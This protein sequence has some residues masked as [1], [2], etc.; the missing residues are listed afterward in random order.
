MS[1]CISAKKGTST[2]FLTSKKMKGSQEDIIDERSED[3]LKEG[4]YKTHRPDIELK[5]RSNY[6][7]EESH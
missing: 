6:D 2:K 3:N 7:G 1:P 5:Y 4:K